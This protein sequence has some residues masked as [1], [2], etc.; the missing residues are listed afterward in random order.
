VVCF[1]RLGLIFASLQFIGID[2]IGGR[3]S[4]ALPVFLFWVRVNSLRACYSNSFLTQLVNAFLTNKEIN[5][6]NQRKYV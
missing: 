4:L 2:L 5:Q 1:Y 3:Y 6:S